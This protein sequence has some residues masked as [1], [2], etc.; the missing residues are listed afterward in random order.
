MAVVLPQGALFRKDAEGRIR[1]ALLE[2]DLIEAV[3]GL[4]PNIF[5]GTGLAPARRGP[6]PHEARRRG[7]ARCSSSTPRA[8]S[9]RAARR[10]SST[11]STPP[12][13]STWVRAF[14][15]VADRAKVVSLDEIKAEDWT[16]NISRYVLPPVG[17]DIPPLP[18]AVAAF[19]QAIAE[20]RAAEDRLRE[21]L[22]RGRLAVM[23]KAPSI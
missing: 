5:Y 16:L 4:A 23:S 13:S 3:I 18:E 2:Q 11:R 8:C 14:E 9:A 1:Q 12:R 17:E 20:A 19:K 15:D 7:R 6:P 21:V 22:T 10:T